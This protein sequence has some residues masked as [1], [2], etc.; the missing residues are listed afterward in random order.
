MSLGIIVPVS[1]D[2]YPHDL[3]KLHTK[4][5]IGEFQIK[6]VIIQEG[7]ELQHYT[8]EKGMCRS[9]FLTSYKTVQLTQSDDSIW[10]SDTPMEY[11]TNQRAIDEAL[12]DVLE[13]GLGIGLF[14][15]YASK[16]KIVRSITIVEKEQDVI[17]LVYP[18]IKNE[19]TKI[20]T[21]D[22]VEYLLKTKQ[23]YDLIHVDLWADIV[24]YKE[25]QP[26]INIAKKKLKLN[27]IVICWLDEF[28]KVVMKNLKLG[29]RDSTG[30][31]YF[32]PCI[33]CGKILRHDYGGF[34]MDC[35]D[36]LGISELG[37]KVKN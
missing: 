15:Y 37:M 11:E 7:K 4:N 6:K 36:G 32:E 17:D 30:I 13:C 21:Q 9:V 25:M 29:K 18:K 10:M 22:A 19:K 23:K 2:Q 28:L 5:S 14:T 1:Y 12:G 33:T 31:G 8:R 3:Y 20:I 27:G 16:K 34:C 35:A 24:H 26:I